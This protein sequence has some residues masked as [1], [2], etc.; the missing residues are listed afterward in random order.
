M[1][2]ASS[3]ALLVLAAASLAG[4]CAA[5]P[6]PGDDTEDGFAVPDGKADDFLSLSAREYIVAGRASVTLEPELATASEQDKLARVHELIGLEQT[7]IAWFLNQYLVDK[8]SEETNAN[9]GGFGAMAKN[10]SYADMNIAAVDALT[11]EFDFRQ[12]IAGRN[13]LID[14]LPLT[15][16]ADG[17]KQLV[18]TI[19][20]PSNAE[21]AELETNAEWYRRAPWGSWSPA[22]VAADQKTDITLTITLERDSNDAW[23]DYAQ[24]FADDKL[25][26]DVHFGW[27]Y[28]SEYHVKHARALFEWLVQQRFHPPVA[29]FEELSRTSGPFTRK[30]DA[31]G[32]PVEI[33]VR[34]FYGKAGSDTDPDTDAGGRVLE[35][36][37]RAS[38][39]DS[40]VIVYS[41][42][43]GPFY[44]FALANWRRTDEGDFDDTEMRTAVMP[45]DRYQIVVAEGCDTY[46]IGAAFAANPNKPDL[47]NVDVITTTSFSNASTPAT[48]ETVITRLLESDSRGHHRPRTVKSLLEDL[49]GNSQWGFHTMYGI[50]GIDDDPHAHPYGHLDNLCASCRVNADCGGLGNMCVGVGSSGRRCAVACTD[51]TGCPSGYGCRL[52][53]SQASRA[54]Y[55]SACVRSDLSCN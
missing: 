53:A 29:T 27:D 49:D 20:K 50:H 42:H 45:S 16:T 34:I 46:Q 3:R 11:Y 43:S 31:D 5:A 23:F 8:E 1:R 24:L 38:L 30:L 47:H 9:Y 12:L 54:I 37:M 19:G 4:A 14:R 25:T 26:L 6:P 35:D 10:G 40:D 21:L 2:S 52:I 32:R 22:T 51:D 18:L 17:A 48:V 39:A 28:H 41:G 33:Q 44:G 55:T 36:D 13:D 7:A 15:T